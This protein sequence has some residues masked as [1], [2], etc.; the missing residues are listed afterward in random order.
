MPDKKIATVKPT[1][2]VKK[3]KDKSFAAKVNRE[4]IYDIEKAG[5]KLE[6]LIDLA[7]EALKEISG[8]IGL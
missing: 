8:E 4:F 5:V 7:L 2:V 1:S 6:E 3:L